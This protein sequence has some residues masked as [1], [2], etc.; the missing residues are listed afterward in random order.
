MLHSLHFWKINL[1]YNC[2]SLPPFRKKHSLL[3]FWFLKFY[4]IFLSLKSKHFS[5]S[6]IY[7]YKH[8]KADYNHLSFWTSNAHFWIRHTKHIP[9]QSNN[10]WDEQPLHWLSL[11]LSLCQLPLL[12][13]IVFYINYSTSHQILKYWYSL[14]VGF[15]LHFLCTS[16]THCIYL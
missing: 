1:K 13:K 6:N 14:H 11:L 10:S 9:H 7:M 3:I 12:A 15:N 8:K 5:C 16:Y 4:S 2:P